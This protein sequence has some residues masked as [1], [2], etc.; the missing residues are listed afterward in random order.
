MNGE[1]RPHFLNII[2]SETSFRLLPAFAFYWTL[3]SNRNG[4]R[5]GEQTEKF[6][7]HSYGSSVRRRI[8]PT[9]KFTKWR[10]RLKTNGENKTVK[11]K[12]TWKVERWDR[13]HMCGRG[14]GCGLLLY[15]FHSIISAIFSF[16]FCVRSSSNCDWILERSAQIYVPIVCIWKMGHVSG[17]VIAVAGHRRRTPNAHHRNQGSNPPSLSLSVSLVRYLFVCTLEVLVAWHIREVRG[18]P[19]T[20]RY[21]KC[22]IGGRWCG[23]MAILQGPRTDR[24]HHHNV[25]YTNWMP[26]MRSTVFNWQCVLMRFLGRRASTVAVQSRIYGMAISCNQY[27]IYEQMHCNAI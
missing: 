11:N 19:W 16:L 2:H 23:I 18:S 9:L 3:H 13:A 15:I 14:R 21:P 10:L 4:D 26:T 27:T 6:V 1:T 7:S 5:S 8:R 17:G 24:P 20:L 25:T 12:N 22:T